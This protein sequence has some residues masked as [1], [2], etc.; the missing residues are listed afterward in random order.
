MYHPVLDCTYCT[1]FPLGSQNHKA[2]SL[3]WLY[4]HNSRLYNIKACNLNKL[5]L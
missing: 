5:T 1:S 4:L 2:A 3:V